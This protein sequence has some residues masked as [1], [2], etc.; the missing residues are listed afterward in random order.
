MNGFQLIIWEMDF[1]ADSMD[2]AVSVLA[3][4]QAFDFFATRFHFF[5]SA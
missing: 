5:F 3:F 1:F 4:I 2:S